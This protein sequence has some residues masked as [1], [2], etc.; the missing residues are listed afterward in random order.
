MYIRGVSTSRAGES[1]LALGYVRVST[2]DQA[3]N[4][5][6]LDTQRA[7]L[8]ADAARRG[9]RLEILADEGISGTDDQRPGLREALTRLD[10]GEV[11]AL[12]V[13]RLD[14][15]TRSVSGLSAVLARAG[16]HGWDLVMLSP[17]IDTTDPAGRF[18]TSILACAAQYERDLIGQRTRE[19]LAHKKAQGGQLGRPRNVDEAVV[20][21]IQA[22]RA[23]R[24]SLR[25][26]AEQLNAEGVPTAQGGAKWHASTVSTVLKLYGEGA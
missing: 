26:I 4:G 16:E 7:L 6:S 3:V 12:M 23:E 14:R 13:T 1:R 18:T 17:A 21:R 20:Q 2:V 8:E 5:L 22:Q 19:A 9:W 15:L 11:T 10:A 24:K 25:A